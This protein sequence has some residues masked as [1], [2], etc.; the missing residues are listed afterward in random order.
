MIPVYRLCEQMNEVAAEKRESRLLWWLK[1]KK[2]K[3]DLSGEKEEVRVV[4]E[5][6]V[7]HY[8]Y[9]QF[10]DFTFQQV[11]GTAM[12]VAFCQILQTFSCLASF[13]AFSFICLSS[14]SS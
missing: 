1:T 10:A 4:V 2:G 9:F 6:E 5:V 8:N 7:A 14:I 11:R 12:G 13:S 3:E